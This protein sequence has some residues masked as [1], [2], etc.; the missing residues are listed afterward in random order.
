MYILKFNLLQI[1][2]IYFNNGLTNSLT[3]HSLPRFLLNDAVMLQRDRFFS[4][5]TR[6]IVERIEYVVNTT[7]RFVVD[8]WVRQWPL[9]LLT[10]WA[11]QDV[12]LSLELIDTAGV[13]TNIAIAITSLRARLFV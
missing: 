8:I 6:M 1:A 10:L 7:T 5:D 13:V 12:W 3:K 9:L 4:K 11:V 2:Q